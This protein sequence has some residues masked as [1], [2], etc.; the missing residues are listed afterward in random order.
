VL[1]AFTHAQ[2]GDI[3]QKAPAS[4]VGDLA[5]GLQELLRIDN[6]V[7]IIGTRHGEK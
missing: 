1:Y 3:L 6:E 5:Q 4:T 7:K 2:P